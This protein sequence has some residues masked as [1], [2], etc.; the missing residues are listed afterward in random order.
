MKR[1]ELEQKDREDQEGVGKRNTPI[2]PDLPDLFVIS[3]IGA[4]Q[5]LRTCVLGTTILSAAGVLACGSSKPAPPSVDQSEALLGGDG[6]IFDEGDESFAYP[7][8]NL[9]QNHRDDF[10]IGDAIFNRNWVPAPGPQGNDGLGPTYNAVSCSS[11]HANNG[12][13]APPQ[14]DGEKFLGLL[15]RLGIDPGSKGVTMPDPNY[16]DQ[17]QPYG[18]FGVPGEGTP[19]VSYVEQP[20]TYGDGSSYSLRKP[21]YSIGSLNFG[22]L[23][24][25]ELIGPRLAPQTIGLGLIEAVDESTIRGFAAN[26]GGHPNDVWDVGKQKSVLGRF[27]WKANQPSVAQQAL[28]ASRNDMGITDSLYPTE[29]CPPVQTACT[30]APQAMDQPNLEPLRENGLIVHAMGLAVPVRRNLDDPAA[31]HGEQLFL[32]AGC[33][34]CHIPKMT[35]GVL[36]DW[37]E[38]SNQTIRPFTDLLLHDMGQELADGRPDAQASGSEWRTPPLWGLGLVQRIDGYFFLMHDGRARGFE[39][40]I[41]WHGGQGQAAREAFRTMSKT[42]RQ[43]LVAFLGS[44]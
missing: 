41:L 16:G 2:L 22:P 38:L 40:A 18:I 8:R 39:E 28:A 15:L 14:A 43:A 10:Q 7:A 44:L 5:R 36:P 21:T 24:A 35:T 12:R 9:S 31:L 13:G 30:A 34:T 26:S 33:A 29:N 25:N 3:K 20:G 32:Q 23:D 27:G 37:P 4:I 6:T 1:R 42:D 19:A 17:L 11:C